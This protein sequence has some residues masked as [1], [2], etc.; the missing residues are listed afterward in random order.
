MI[1]T[2]PYYYI[3]SGYHDIES[4]QTEIIPAANS[5]DTIRNTVLFSEDI[6]QKGNKKEHLAWQTNKNGVLYAMQPPF[7]MHTAPIHKVGNKSFHI[8]PKDILIHTWAAAGNEWAKHLSE[9]MSKNNTQGIKFMPVALK[10]GQMKTPEQNPTTESGIEYKAWYEKLTDTEELNGYMLVKTRAITLLFSDN[11]LKGSK[12]SAQI[13]DSNIASKSTVSIQETSDGILTATIFGT[14][15]K[16]PKGIYTFSI[17]LSD[18]AYKELYWNSTSLTDKYYTITERVRFEITNQSGEFDLIIADPISVEEAVMTQ[19]PTQFQHLTKAAKETDT[20][21]ELKN[22]KDFI[23]LP[24][25]LEKWSK[26]LATAYSSTKLSV[27]VINAD[28]NNDIAKVIGNAVWNEIDPKGNKTLELMK[29]SIDL[30][31]G[32]NKAFADWKDVL[33]TFEGRKELAGVREIIKSEVKGFWKQNQWLDYLDKNYVG[34]SK[35]VILT[36][37]KLPDIDKKNLLAA[38]IPEKQSNLQKAL[39]TSGK[40]IEKAMTVIDT[41][42]SFY[43]CAMALGAVIG[44]NN[45]LKQNIDTYNNLS[46]QYQELFPN[47]PSRE[48]INNLEKLRAATVTGEIGFD[49]AK[50]KA[51]SKAFDA[52]IGVLCLIPG[53]NFGAGV[54][55]LVKGTAELAESAITNATDWADQLI[56][57][58][59][60][61][62]LKNDL[63][64][65]G[66]ISKNSFANQEL[67]FDIP[68][69]GGINDIAIQFRVR[70]EA[71]YG[72]L[73]LLAR[74]SVTS[75]DKDSYLKKLEK[76]KV[77]EY[78]E[79]FIFNDDWVIP[80][81]SFIPVSMDTFWLYL[82]DGSKKANYSYKEFQSNFGH[83]NSVPSVLSLISGSMYIMGKT[84]DNLADNTAKANFHN[85]F[86]IQTRDAD[87]FNEFASAFRLSYPEI[88]QECIEYTCIY[89]R[90]RN[91]T[92]KDE[93]VPVNSK[94]TSVVEKLDVLSPFDQ[95]RILIVLKEN[96]T[97]AIYPASLQIFRVDKLIKVVGPEYRD[98]IRVLDPFLLDNEKQWQGR[99]GCVFHPFYQFATSTIPGIKPLAPPTFANL[100]GIETYYRH[101]GLFNMRY[102]FEVKV[103]GEKSKQ[104]IDIGGNDG[105]PTGLDEVVLTVN[106][107][108]DKDQGKFIMKDFLNHGE[109]TFPFPSVVDHGRF[110]GSNHCYIKVGN[111]AK[112]QC[113]KNG[114]DIIFKD[115]N[116]QDSV[117]FIIIVWTTKFNFN[118]F[119]RTGMNWKKIPVEVDLVNYEGLDK[120]GPTYSST[121]NFIGKY[122]P[123]NKDLRTE[124]SENIHSE[125]N[126][127][128]EDLKQKDNLNAFDEALDPA[129][130]PIPALSLHSRSSRY[131]LFAAHFKMKYQTPTGDPVSSIRPFA[132]S[133]PDADEYYRYAITNIKSVSNS[134]IAIDKIK[135]NEGECQFQ[136]KAP[137]DHKHNV[138][139]S[140]VKD[141]KKWIE[142]DCKQIVPDLK[143][144]RD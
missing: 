65:T 106:H 76:Y 79:L 84:I 132:N 139:W 24:T 6:R 32:V 45:E 94:N 61:A 81:D 23:P 2:I 75:K 83:Y 92:K 86:P 8:P 107:M 5:V 115:F 103:G 56:L 100:V 67:F 37:D 80:I 36:L 3:F 91:S 135:S 27:A 85:F 46:T 141:I 33:K 101:G 110:Q 50:A 62:S 108:Q 95:I 17:E 134:G 96:I 116:W 133:I 55:A 47:A 102:G 126:A 130:G 90:S 137:K 109:I 48:G 113:A 142:E 25:P 10:K 97:H 143:I 64:I 52:A 54:I 140:N 35:A 22:K 117:E 82:F 120:T 57:H 44:S 104:M 98:N 136:F 58:N 12:I 39:G 74:A 34:D 59:Y 144:V 111:A 121:L 71:L 18:M 9:Y 43:E 26:R 51:A 68:E 38:G 4:G 21:P 53:V 119:I 49:E 60:F 131:N 66:D 105:K 31:F 124:S 73:G 30:G 29:D 118:N 28:S 42:L 125:I 20:Y 15:D 128:I 127:L 19:F 11:R 112:Y 40:V 78:M 69:D 114:S 77:K 89:K 72:L 1:K 122:A 129:K 93:W 14:P 13:H 138:P 88:D 70:S 87:T 7:G 63:K 16:L 123:A 99:I 41:A